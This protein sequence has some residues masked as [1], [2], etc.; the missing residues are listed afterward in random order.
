MRNKMPGHYRMDNH[1]TML[2]T[3]DIVEFVRKNTGSESITSETDIFSDGTV[4]DDFHDLVEN[5]AKTYSVDMTNYLWYFHS[6]EEGSWNSIGGLFFDPPNK[7][8]ERIPVTPALLT[9]F[10]NKRKW[11][12]KYPKHTIPEKR[13]DILINRIFVCQNS[14]TDYSR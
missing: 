9:E 1:T 8:V 10:A 5:F 13:Y 11:E 6:D 12:L 14:M 7:R 3:N 2:T 4:G